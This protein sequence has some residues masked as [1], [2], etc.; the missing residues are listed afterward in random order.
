MGFTENKED[1]AAA[2]SEDSDPHVIA[3]VRLYRALER[4][5][6]AG[7]DSTLAIAG[8][9]AVA[10]LSKGTALHTRS[11][12]LAWGM[13]R[14]VHTVHTDVS[15]QLMGPS[16]GA[17]AVPGMDALWPHLIS[18]LERPPCFSHALD[19]VGVLAG[20][21]DKPH[22]SRARATRSCEALLKAAL[23]PSISSSGAA[24]WAQSGTRS[25]LTLSDESHAMAAL[26]NS[27]NTWW[28]HELRSHRVFGL[29]ALLQE[30]LRRHFS[31]TDRAEG[32]AQLS[33]VGEDEQTGTDALPPALPQDSIFRGMTE[34]N[35][36]RYLAL[37]LSLLPAALL[38]SKPGQS[39]ALASACSPGPY[40]DQIN[41][42]KTFLILGCCAVGST[43]GA[44]YAGHL[45]R[46]MN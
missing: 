16:G 28:V 39:N 29:A 42:C 31:P 36:D 24:S 7:Q 13:A 14:A 38:A 8:L 37:A 20:G 27:I 46:A 2:D 25:G 9:R 41:A 34:Q 43:S 44:F 6:R 22:G 30:T 45:Y 4:Q 12:S 21:R 33:G 1:G 40:A 35:A 23:N 19:E 10:A 11:C 17:H 26:R 3:T 15:A 18:H 5:L 32:I